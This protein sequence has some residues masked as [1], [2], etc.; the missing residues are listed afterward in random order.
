MYIVYEVILL[1]YPNIN[2]SLV[3]IWI[4]SA[5]ISEK[6]DF[7]KGLLQTLDVIPKDLHTEH[8]LYRE[9]LDVIEIQK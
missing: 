9:N 6:C 5:W 2:A 4:L 1:L 7:L 3:I 8:K